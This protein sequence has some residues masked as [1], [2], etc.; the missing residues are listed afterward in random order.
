MINVGRDFSRRGKG[1]DAEERILSRKFLSGYKGNTFVT[2]AEEIPR[3]AI[4]Y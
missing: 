4:E 3:C 1:E 2:V